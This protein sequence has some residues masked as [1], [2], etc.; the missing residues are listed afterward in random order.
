MIIKTHSVWTVAV[1]GKRE[2]SFL[3][4]NDLGNK[5]LSRHREIVYSAHLDNIRGRICRRPTF[6]EGSSVDFE[7]GP[8]RNSETDVPLDLFPH[9]REIEYAEVRLIKTT[10]IKV[11]Y[12][13]RPELLHYRKLGVEISFEKNFMGVGSEAVHRALECGKVK[14][15]GDV[16]DM[17]DRANDI[18]DAARVF[19][20]EFVQSVKIGT[21]DV[22]CF[23]AHQQ[24]YL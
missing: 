12:D 22:L 3:I 1:I 5:T 15:D 4:K 24:S 14:V 16:V 9:R 21:G 11:A 13:L 19:L 18:L 17:V 20:Q 8:I 7:Q 10:Q 2:P 6:A 23:Q